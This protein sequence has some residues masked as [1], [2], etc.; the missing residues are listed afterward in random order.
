MTDAEGDGVASWHD[1]DCKSGNGCHAVVN[2]VIDG[3]GMEQAATLG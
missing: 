3:G 1:R 2:E